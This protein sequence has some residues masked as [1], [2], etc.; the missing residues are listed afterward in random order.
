MAVIILTLLA[1]IGV[2]VPL[3]LFG[4]R[5]PLKSAVERVLFSVFIGIAVASIIY[6]VAIAS[7]QIVEIGNRPN[8]AL[9]ETQ[10]KDLEKRYEIIDKKVYNKDEKVYYESTVDVLL[11]NYDTNT[12]EVKQ[13]VIMLT[14]VRVAHFDFW[15]NPFKPTYKNVIQIH[16]VVIPRDAAAVKK[17]PQ[18]VEVFN[19]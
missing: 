18:I 6:L 13:P 7:V 15:G 11:S 2:T 10:L 5:P 17:T 9:S 19:N 14:Q 8:V 3:I 4:G 16:K 1:V 12:G